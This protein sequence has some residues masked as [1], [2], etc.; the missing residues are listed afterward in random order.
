MKIITL[1]KKNKILKGEINLPASKS[2]SNRAL[3]INYLSDNQQHLT[4]LSKSDDT[5][6]MKHLL[7]QIAKNKSSDFPVH[8]NCDNAGTVLRF[9][10][11][12]LAITPGNWVLTG[13]QRMKERPI[14]ILVDALNQLGA[15]IN[16]LEKNGF[17]PLQIKS[18]PLK[19]VKLKIDGSV[20]S[21]FIS[22]LI[23]IAPTLRN[24]L[25]LSI[26][27]K[28]SSKPYIDMTLKMLQ[29]FGVNYRFDG[30]EIYIQHQNYLDSELSIEPDWSAAA[31]WYEMAALSDEAD[32][33]LRD[34]KYENRST[35]T[36][37]LGLSET[38]QSLQG[39]A[40]LPEIYKSFAVKTELLENGIRLTKK[41][42]TI[43]KFE[44]DFTNQP[45]LAQ[46]TIVTCAALGIKGRFKGLESLRIKETDRLNALVNELTKFGVKCLIKSDSELHISNKK[47]ESESK[48]CQSKILA[49]YNDHRMAMSFAPLAMIFKEI[50]I[51]NPDVVSKSYPGFWTELN[52]VG[53]NY[54]LSL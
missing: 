39:D 21:Q 53:I 19:G 6:L 45:D 47:P 9:L 28:I 14:G 24:G 8:L 11:A 50:Q 41:G 35:S 27:N 12:L 31:Y 34:I 7:L 18:K 37:N 46:S 25:Q 33:L 15:E 3:I 42:K 52:S 20:S 4:N 36:L 16:C 30:K 32:I 22:A 23:L 29:H 38:Q 48:K 49:T 1:S 17:P 54:S 43:E 40:I 2:I 51:E 10:T 26:T 44:F 5:Q 13:T